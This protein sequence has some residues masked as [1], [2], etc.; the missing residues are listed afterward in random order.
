MIYGFFC[1]FVCL[2]KGHLLD[3]IVLCDAL[4]CP[5]CTLDTQG[6]DIWHPSLYCSA[7]PAPPLNYYYLRGKN[8]KNFINWNKSNLSSQKKKKKVKVI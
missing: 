3:T 6:F 5:V 2:F 4:M 7:P 8:I 1:L